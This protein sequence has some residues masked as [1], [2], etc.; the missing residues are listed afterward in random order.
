MIAYITS[1]G[2]EPFKYAVQPRVSGFDSLYIT[3]VGGIIKRVLDL[4]DL[5]VELLH[6]S[7]RF[8]VVYIL[9]SLNL[10]KR[11][12]T[13]LSQSRSYGRRFYIAV[14]LPTASVVCSSAERSTTTTD[15]GLYR[16]SF[17]AR[18]IPNLL[19]HTYDT[20]VRHKRW[21][22]VI[23]IRVVTPKLSV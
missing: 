14:S 18:L 8:L 17:L 5:V 15:K 23:W 19:S 7:E 21:A 16:T 4:K 11:A 10:S 1:Y 20:F 22:Q 12:L 2:R 3:T 6:R 9:F 13:R